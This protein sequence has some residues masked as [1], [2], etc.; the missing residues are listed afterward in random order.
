MCVVCTC[1]EVVCVGVYIYACVCDCGVCVWCTCVGGV[2]DEPIVSTTY[3]YSLSIL[4]SSNHCLS[5]SIPFSPLDPLSPPLWTPLPS[6]LDT[7]SPPLWTPSPLPS[8]P[9]LPHHLQSY[10]RSSSRVRMPASSSAQ[11]PPPSPT[12]LS[13][14]S[15]GGEATM[16]C[17]LPGHSTWGQRPSEC[18]EMYVHM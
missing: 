13:S 9:P 16:T 17:H 1:G 10:H 14:P 15:P 6:P 8:G 11:R 12:M 4:S 18:L 2:Y 5:I 7:F 3:R